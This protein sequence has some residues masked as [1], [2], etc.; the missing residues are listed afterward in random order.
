[1]ETAL[2]TDAMA[3]RRLDPGPGLEAKETSIHSLRLGLFRRGRA[4]H[5]R[6]GGGTVEFNSVKVVNGSE[7]PQ[8]LSRLFYI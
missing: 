2:P 1:M 6:G 3:P 5:D 7:R 4:T 8:T